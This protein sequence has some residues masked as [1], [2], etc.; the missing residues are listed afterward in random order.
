MRGT[1][2]ALQLLVA[3]FL[4]ILG[5]AMA[6]RASDTGALLIGSLLGAMGLSLLGLMGINMRK[7]N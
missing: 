1:F 6:F 5:L 3:F 7:A 2:A 4:A